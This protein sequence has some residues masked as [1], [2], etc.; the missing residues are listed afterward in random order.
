MSRLPLPPCRL[1]YLNIA[2]NLCTP[3]TSANATFVQSS[4]N[5]TYSH[6]GAL[7]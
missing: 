6:S 2:P 4:N 3:L 5:A 7:G 1:Y